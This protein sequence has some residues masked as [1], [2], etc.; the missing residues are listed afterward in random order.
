MNNGAIIIFFCLGMER[1][2][3]PS[4]YRVLAYRKRPATQKLKLSTYLL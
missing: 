3:A 1:Q 2:L 4:P